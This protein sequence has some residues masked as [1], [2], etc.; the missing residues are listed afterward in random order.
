MQKITLSVNETAEFIGVSTTTIYA[1]AREEQI[2]HVRVRGRILFHREV[3]EA[4]LRGEH[5]QA[6]LA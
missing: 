6:K 3:I 5:S 4:W 2:P 1:M